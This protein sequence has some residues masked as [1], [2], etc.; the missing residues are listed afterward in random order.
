MGESDVGGREG[1]TL[2]RFRRYQFRVHLGRVEMFPHPKLGRAYLRPPLLGWSQL[3][4][5]PGHIG[6]SGTEHLAAFYEMDRA[7]LALKAAVEA[8]NQPDASEAQFMKPWLSC[9]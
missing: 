1:P 3:A 2:N 8:H 9:R 7:L 4:E 6:R 5:G